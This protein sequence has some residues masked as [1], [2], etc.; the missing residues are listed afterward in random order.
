MAGGKNITEI[1]ILNLLDK[2][3]M[4]GAEMVE[5][6]KKLSGNTVIMSLPTLYSSLHR[7]AN[8]KWVN[9]YQKQSA[10]GGRCRVY[11]ITKTG[12]EYLSKNPLHIDYSLINSLN[13]NKIQQAALSG[14]DSFSIN[15]PTE[16]KFAT[17]E[18]AFSLPLSKTPKPKLP[19][20]KELPVTES[21][22]E[23]TQISIPEQI[24]PIVKKTTEQATETATKTKSKPEIIPYITP[25][26]KITT[27]PEPDY[28]QTLI[29]LSGTIGGNNLR[30]ILKLNKVKV[31][32]D[33]VMINR[34]RMVATAL[35]FLIF[36]IIN[37]FCSL[38]QASPEESYKLVYIILMIYTLINLAIY[39]VYPR[40]KVVFKRKSSFLRYL[41]ATFILFFLVML[42]CFVYNATNLLWLTIFTFM[43]ITQFIIMS[44]L[45]K[46]S[47]FEC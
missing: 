17:L 26:E 36:T 12:R 11:N 5:E 33:Y 20:A 3:A 41:L 40:I 22:A 25:N 7:M 38:T 47:W 21:V 29:G 30:P 15:E 44:S 32:N 45:R 1:T 42:Y 4:Y 46:R 13:S 9:S 34:L 16:R 27:T 14:N 39:F 43:P 37:F 2:R 24:E 8:K 23:N 10:I 19:D 6:I 35:C 18:D 31:G 28:E